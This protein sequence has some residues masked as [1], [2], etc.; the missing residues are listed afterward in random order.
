MYIC[1]D[2]SLDTSLEHQLDPDG[3]TSTIYISIG[4]YL[5]KA[6]FTHIR[7]HNANKWSDEDGVATKE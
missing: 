5:I 4:L 1:I 3:P 6:T 2:R 7:N